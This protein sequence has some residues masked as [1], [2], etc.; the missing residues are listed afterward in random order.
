[1]GVQL[2]VYLLLLFFSLTVDEIYYII[3]K[4]TGGMPEGPKSRPKRTASEAMQI[5]SPPSPVDLC[6]LLHIGDGPPLNFNLF[7][8]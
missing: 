5:L 8:T 2:H 3:R 7:L 1:M 6:E 4:E